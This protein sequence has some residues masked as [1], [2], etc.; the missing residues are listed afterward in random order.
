ML[1]HV[2]GQVWNAAEPAR[3]LGVAEKTA[4]R[5]LDALVSTFVVRRLAPWFANLKK[6]EVKAPKI[7]VADTGLLHALLSLQDRDDLLAHPKAG[8]SW[9]GF[10]IGQLCERLG[11]ASDEAYFWGVH[12]GA[13][14][15][16]LVARGRARRGFE[17]KLTDAPRV[18]PSMRSA[19]DVLALDS[20]DVV[21]AGP[22]TFPLAPRIRAVS[23]RRLWADVEPL[24]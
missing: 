6:R 8:A 11:A 5:H 24:G 12:T 2:H 7:Y 3:A 1:A 20:L 15:D 21:H 18:T 13:E 23:A 16:L 19:L 4:R 10:V 17:I 14:L 9:E 22:D